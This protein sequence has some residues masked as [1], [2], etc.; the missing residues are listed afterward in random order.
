VD[1]TNKIGKMPKELCDLLDSVYFKGKNLPI[2]VSHD[3]SIERGG[4]D[5]NIKFA[6]FSWNGLE[7]IGVYQDG[8][9]GTD[10]VE[11]GVILK[12]NKSETLRAI[13]ENV[14]LKNMKWTIPVGMYDGGELAIIENDGLMKGVKVNGTGSIGLCAFSGGD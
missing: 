8:Q 1:L 10:Y 9:S 14:G 12:S 5:L 6:P 11:T 13:R 7:V 2:P 4:Y 3:M